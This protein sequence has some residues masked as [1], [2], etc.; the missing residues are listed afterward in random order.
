M[1]GY[2]YLINVPANTPFKTPVIE[3]HGVKPGLIN[4]V[5]VEF[6]YGCNRLVFVKIWIG[7]TPLIPDDKGEWLQGNGHIYPYLMDFEVEAM[8]GTLKII[9]ASPG[10]LFDHVVN[11]GL[12]HSAI[13]KPDTLTPAINNLKRSVDELISVTSQKGEKTTNLLTQLLGG[14]IGGKR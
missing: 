14:L 10:A 3:E 5:H 2:N 7:E 9:A 4:N 6:P 8:Q 13:P 1:T 12:G 11:V